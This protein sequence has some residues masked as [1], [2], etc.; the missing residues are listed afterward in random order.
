M[1]VKK[2]QLVFNLWEITC[3]KNYLWYGVIIQVQGLGS[4]GQLVQFDGV[5][6][7]PTFEWSRTVLLSP[8]H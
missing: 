1:R 4:H 2:G 6:F 7:S 8:L 5:L 3:F